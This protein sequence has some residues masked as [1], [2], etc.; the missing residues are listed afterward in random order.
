MLDMA[1]E[2]LDLERE[3]ERE[4][5]NALADS[6]SPA[7]QQRRGTAMHRLKVLS[8]ETVLFGRVQ[9]TLQLSGGRQLPP[10]KLTNG[11]LVALRPAS[12]LAA[13][14]ATGTVT[15]LR[16]TSISVSFEEMPEEQQLAPEPLTL[17]L[18]YN[19]VT[20]RRLEAT[21]SALRSGGDKV[22]RAASSLCRALLSDEATSRAAMAAA[23]AAGAASEPLAAERAIN[24][25]LNEGQLRAIG[26]GLAA[27]PVALIHGPP[28]TGK[29]TAVVEL[30]RQAVMRGERVLASA[31][32]NVAVDNMAERLL[33]GNGSKQL[34]LVRIGHPA[35]LLPSVLEASLDARLATSDGAAI[36]RDVKADL[37]GARARL[38]KERGKGGRAALK[39]EVSTLRK[40]LTQRQKKS[41]KDLLQHASVVLCTNTGAADRALSCLPD[42]FAFDLVVIDEAAQALEASCWVA[43]LKGARAVLAGDHLQL[44]PVVKSEAAARKG[45][46]VTLFERLLRTHGDGVGVM[47]TEQYRMNGD[48]CRWAS[49]ELYGG[50]LVPHASVA[51]HTLAELG[52]VEDTEDTEATLL[53]ID[54]TGCDCEEDAPEDGGG[55]SGSGGGG[56]GGGGGDKGG[57]KGDGRGGGGGG[58]ASSSSKLSEMVAG[59][60]S[61]AAEARLVGEHVRALLKAGLRHD[62]IGVITPYNAQVER[63]RAELAEERQVPSASGEGYA[64]EVGTVDGFQ[65]RE[66]EAII[67]SLVRSNARREVGFLAEDRRMNVAITRG[68]RHV[69]LIGD[70]DTAS[71]HPFLRR[72]ME[73]FEANGEVRSA[74]QYGEDA[75]SGGPRGARGGGGGGSAAFMARAKA[76]QAAA[77]QREKDKED[78]LRSRMTAFLADE[79]ANALPLPASLSSYE[80]M[81]AHRL[82]A[83]LGLQHES[84]GEGKGRFITL[85]KASGDGATADVGGAL[86]PTSA[87]AAAA[88]SAEAASAEAAYVDISEAADARPAPA[89]QLRQEPAK[90]KA[91]EAASSSSSAPAVAQSPQPA[92]ATAPQSQPSVAS[93]GGLTAGQQ[94]MAARVRELFAALTAAGV[95]PTD[96]AARAIAEAKSEA[97]AAQAAQAA[98]SSAG[99]GASAEQPAAAAGPAS[100]PIAFAIQRLRSGGVPLPRVIPALQL[101]TKLLANVLSK[102]QEPKYRVVRCSNA[103]LSAE[104]FSVPGGRELLIASGFE[105]QRHGESGGDGAE[106]ADELVLPEGASLERLRA[107]QKALDEAAEAAAAKA[108]AD[109]AA[110]EARAAQAGSNAVLLSVAAD[111]QERERAAAAERARAEAAAAAAMRQEEEERRKAM[112]RAK[113]DKRKDKKAAEVVGG[114]KAEG[115]DEDDI[116]AALAALG[117]G[118]D[119]N[120][121]SAAAEA[122]GLGGAAQLS[123]SLP[124]GRDRDAERER[125]RLKARLQGKIAGGESHKKAQPKKG[126]G[127]K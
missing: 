57:G 61:N 114:S 92:L 9:L 55:N 47:L 85:R 70:A 13:G 51:S 2:C 76:E 3:A 48:I 122:A 50:R 113:K 15:A 49:D 124:W 82:A 62:E 94:E 41:V 74:A 89:E 77:A 20:Y 91:E 58:A 90:A 22:P 23:A 40:E 44:P 43:L 112:A 87:A 53:L 86:P 108:A 104:L 96:A 99:K 31:A 18:L 46:G 5:C 38:R 37:E 115:G 33:A 75:V 98:S 65:G 84:S 88:A 60:K 56:G 24:R 32:S 12:V 120:G 72:M 4:E 73:Y 28:G 93:S 79:A 34:K 83:E 35:R 6:L 7:E 106:G 95:S 100:T 42:D 118:A 39:A 123:S 69:C 111:R 71:A 30:I 25:G 67:I 68:R 36:C 29:T 78:G 11:A 27:S 66:K 103:K 59:S 102:P 54:T 21:I 10:T 1:M 17:S 81:L 105:L 45:F 125:E 97:Q 14:A 116:D 80:R 19:D 126:G 63:L 127:K 109:T 119:G 110:A 8:V 26:F 16:A 117:L 121:E 64:L 101:A 107:C 52:H